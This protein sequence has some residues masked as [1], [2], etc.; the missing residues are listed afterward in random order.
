[1]VKKILSL[2][3]FYLLFQNSF[4]QENRV[5]INGVVLNPSSKALKNS[6]IL[7]L[8]T[9]SGTI[10]NKDGS[11]TISAKKGDWLQIT[12]I[13]FHSKKIKIAQNI[14]KEQF[15]RVYLLPIL[16]QLDEVEIKKKMKGFLSLD[17]INTPKDTIGDL[18]KGIM[19]IPYKEIMGMGVGNDERHLQKPTVKPGILPGLKG[20]GVSATIPYADL[21][22][23]RANRKKINFKEQ[24]PE[25]LKKIFGEHFFLVRLKIPKE[26]YH[27]FL[28]YCN[29]LGIEELYKS[30]KHL[31]ILK[32]L[33]KESKS[34]LLL[35]ENN[36]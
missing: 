17:R 29:P 25:S 35:L 26:K 36:K 23:K 34:Y 15:L 11:F 1:M 9:N 6:H 10:S 28:E 21:K 30:R 19:S 8:T 14:R 2:F 3:L 16:N 27:H 33:L 5:E 4:S 32:I 13:Q 20:V 7:N 18:V 12:N 22:K 31:D 24:L